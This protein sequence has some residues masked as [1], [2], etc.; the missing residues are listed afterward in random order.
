MP[1]QRIAREEWDDFLSAFSAHN[2]TRNITVEV[3]TSDLG[4]QRLMDDQPLLG[5]EPNLEDKQQPGIILVAGDPQGGEPAALTH[6]IVK[7]TAI[8]L[9]AADDGQAQA[10]DIE[11]EDGRT[12]IQ[13]A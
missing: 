9:K 12:I 7:P 11:T 8:W 1:T 10:L 6:Q 4:P 3:Q 2:Q 5:L 13:F